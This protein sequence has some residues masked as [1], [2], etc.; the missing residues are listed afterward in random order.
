MMDKDT[1]QAFLELKEPKELYYP[2][3]YKKNE[4]FS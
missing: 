1:T 3:N 2:H 4:D